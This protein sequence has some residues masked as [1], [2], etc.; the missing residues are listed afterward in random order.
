MHFNGRFI[1]NLAQFA[2]QL[3]ANPSEILALSG[4]PIAELCK[5]ETTVDAVSYN[6]VI[7]AAVKATNDP[8]F[9]LHAGENLN[10]VAAGII[11]QIANTSS[12]VKEALEYCCYFANLGCSALPV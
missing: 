2:G 7:E 10:L 6:E 1:V 9:G 11:V 12:T 8:F 5:E 4:L 3:G